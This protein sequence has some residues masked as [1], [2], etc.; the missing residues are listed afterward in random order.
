MF[1]Y[2]S[3]SAL[4]KKSQSA[5]WCVASAA[6]KYKNLWALNF[7]WCRSRSPRRESVQSLCC[8]NGR[9][10]YSRPMT[11]GS[12]CAAWWSGRYGASHVATAASV[13]WTCSSDAR[14]APTMTQRRLRGPCRRRRAAVPPGLEGTRS[15]AAKRP[16]LS[17][18]PS[19]R[20]ASRSGHSVRARTTR[21]LHGGDA[22]SGL[23]R[24]VMGQPARLGP[25]Q[26]PLTTRYTPRRAA[27]LWQATTRTQ[28]ANWPRARSRAYPVLRTGG[29]AAPAA[30]PWGRR[31]SRT[32]SP[33]RCGRRP[34]SHHAQRPT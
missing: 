21:R 7:G 33:R 4:R 13:R 27:G 15:S 26:L 1:T 19:Q 16:K 32:S 29:E 22:A 30:I 3:G 17:A 28:C 20:S 31:T 10:L 2:E 18:G 5:A 23:A 25:S 34:S 14:L 24:P 11:L 6:H 12:A 8:F 9:R